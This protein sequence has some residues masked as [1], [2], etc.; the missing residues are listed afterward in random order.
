MKNIFFLALGVLFFAAC[1]D[2]DKDPL[3][4]E[5][6]TKGSLIALRGSA[7]DNL[8][9]LPFRG[10]VDSFSISNP[11]LADN[12]FEFQADFLSDD[13]SSLSKVEVYASATDGGTRARVLTKD[14]ADF[15]PVSGSK[16]PRATFSITTN[17]ILAALSLN[18][19]DIAPY[20]YLY[21]ECDIT[22]KD[23]TVIPASAFS[24]GN[25]YE[26]SIFYPA[27]KLR[28]LAGQ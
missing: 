2:P 28:Y 19:A 6:I 21:I 10:A 13:L 4:F 3:Q 7:F 23:G 11:D 17:D 18:R 20:S 22:L 5:K 1:S 16:Y 15:Q 12:T 27:H 24:N 25:L 26:S 14:G 8:S 9:K